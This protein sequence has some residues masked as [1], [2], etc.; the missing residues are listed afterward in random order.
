MLQHP[1][2][3]G[4]N[5]KPQASEK[6]TWSA[7]EGGTYRVEEENSLSGSN[8]VAIRTNTVSGSAT[9][10][11][12]ETNG[13]GFAARFYRVART[14]LASYD[15]A[16]TNSN[17]SSA[18]I[19][20]SPASG[21]NGNTYSVTA[22]IS[23][24]ATPPPPP[25]SGAPVLVFTV[26]TIN[27]TGAAY[28]L[29]AAGASATGSLPIPGGYTPIGW[30]NGDDYSRRHRCSSKGDFYADDGFTIF[31]SRANLRACR[32]PYKAI[33]YGKPMVLCIAALAAAG[34][35]S[36]PAAAMKSAAS[37]SGRT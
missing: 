13:A 3:A 14:A 9:G 26:G 37:A 29:V 10:S 18:I 24:S 28:T 12:T 25:V 35:R 19:T 31:A 6:L 5:L 1:A 7:I 27:V 8:W 30:S 4:R 15:S 2:S 36:K 33:N 22:T 32:A 23:A 20:M 34:L 16:G 11:V 17:S 21:T